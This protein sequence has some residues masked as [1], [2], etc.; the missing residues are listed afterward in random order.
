[1]NG[2]PKHDG[3]TTSVKIS[4]EESH[5]LHEQGYTSVSFTGW[6]L[7]SSLTIE[8]NSD[9]CV[10][11][12]QANDSSFNIIADGTLKVRAKHTRPFRTR[13]KRKS[14]LMIPDSSLT[15]TYIR[16]QS[17]G[18][19]ANKWHNRNPF[20]LVTLPLLS[21]VILMQLKYYLRSQN[22]L[23]YQHMAMW[24]TNYWQSVDKFCL[25]P[26]LYIVLTKC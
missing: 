21:D 23:T 3:S 8:S 6:K 2:C 1:M 15:F 19:V 24:N 14:S 12:I 18:I 4:K 13:V 7:T 10:S 20:W 9:S 11:I 26:N 16:P 25:Y 5:A 22:I 17:V